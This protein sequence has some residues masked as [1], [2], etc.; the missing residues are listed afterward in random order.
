MGVMLAVLACAWCGCEPSAQKPRLAA[1]SRP[2]TMP[3][4]GP[5]PAKALVKL[6][7]LTPRIAK[8]VNPSGID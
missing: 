8:P 6:D 2:A 1:T 3:P 4:L 7:D 5:L